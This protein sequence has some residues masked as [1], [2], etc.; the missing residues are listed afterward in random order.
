MEQVLVLA[1]VRTPVGRR[2]GALAGL[3]PASLLGHV[4]RGVLASA[5]LEPSAVGQVI[6]GCVTQVGEQ[7][8]NITRTAWLAAGLPEQVAACTVDAQCG[9][10]QQALTLAAGLIGAGVVDIA[11]ACGAESMSRVPIGANFRKDLG[12]G[13]PVPPEY[14]SRYEFIN[15]FQAAE[16]IAVKWGVSRGDADALGLESQQRAARAL[17]QDRFAGQVLPVPVT[18][19]DGDGVVSQ[20]GGLRQTSLEALAQLNAVIPRARPR[21]SRTGPAPSC[22]PASGEP[23]SWG[24]RR[25]RASWTPA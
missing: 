25:W 24:S 12:L 5:G 7:S 17:A 8:Y 19:E 4:Q 15:Q 14:F 22:W 18:G 10:S 11:I 6:G 1:A 9:S 3:H 23:P 2:G 20:D 13:R 21:R 16:R